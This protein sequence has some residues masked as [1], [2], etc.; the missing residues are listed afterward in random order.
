MKGL[1]ERASTGNVSG[2][3][4]FKNRALTEIPKL[5][6]SVSMSVDD[7]KRGIKRGLSAAESWR[8]SSR[9]FVIFLGYIRVSKVQGSKVLD[10]PG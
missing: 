3:A 6:S 2:I 1:I 10:V 9:R 8:R 5:R 4:R 7:L